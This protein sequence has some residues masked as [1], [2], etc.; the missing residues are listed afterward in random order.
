MFTQD[1]E[2]STKMRQT[3]KDG[4]E[5]GEKKRPHLPRLAYRR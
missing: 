1:L 2:C 4:G 3:L 5:R